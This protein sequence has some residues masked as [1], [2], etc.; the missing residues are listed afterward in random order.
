VKVV[1]AGQEHDKLRYECG[2]FCVDPVE[3]MLLCAGKPVSLMPKSCDV[4][5]VL[6][7]N[8]GKLLDKDFLLNSVWSDGAVEENSLARAVADIRR[9][10]G[11]GPK[12]NRFIAT[13][14]RH[15]YRFV[16]KVTSSTTSLA[17]G[18]PTASDSFMLP[19]AG[20][21]VAT[22]AVLPFDWLTQEGS[23]GSLAVGPADAL[24]TRLSN[25]TQIVVRPTSSILKYPRPAGS[26]LRV[27]R[28]LCCQRPAGR[29]ASPS[30]RTDGEPE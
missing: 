2:S 21:K 26:R 16:A 17:V 11:E 13:V 5:V 10:L 25:L 12:D 29:R 14:A 7:Q 20:D 9:A 8:S 3:R 27:E 19:V 15:C 1:N 23:D 6:L 24:I 18:A 4:L 30:D 22:L 28:G